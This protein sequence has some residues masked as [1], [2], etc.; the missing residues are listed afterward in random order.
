MDIN[1]N[2]DNITIRI[3]EIEDEKNRLSGMLEVMNTLKSMGVNMVNPENLKDT[4][5]NEV[6][7]EETVYNYE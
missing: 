6:I 1:K 4:N 7:D 3:K 2:I 5:T